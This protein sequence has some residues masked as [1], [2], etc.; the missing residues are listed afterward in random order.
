[1]PGFNIF[2][3]GN[4]T[5]LIH[6]HEF[7]LHLLDMAQPSSRTRH[8]HECHDDVLSRRLSRAVVACVVVLSQRSLEHGVLLARYWGVCCRWRWYVFGSGWV[9]LIVSLLI[10]PSPFYWISPLALGWVSSRPWSI[11]DKN[12]IRCCLRRCV[13]RKWHALGH[14]TLRLMFPPILGYGKRDFWQNTHTH[15]H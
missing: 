10:F 14:P 2:I 11:T 4:N 7:A 3:M 12:C 15:T 1:M 5:C 6:I 9:A 13:K 8:L